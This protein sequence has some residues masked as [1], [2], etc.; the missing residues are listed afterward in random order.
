MA[1]IRITHSMVG[2]LVPASAFFFTGKG[3]SG[4]IWHIFDN[5][6]GRW[7][8]CYKCAQDSQPTFDIFE[9]AILLEMFMD[10]ME[11]D[12]NETIGTGLSG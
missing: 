12:E 4:W 8:I 11:D 7:A 1:S 5:A 10:G 9:S 3:W 2:T 6:H